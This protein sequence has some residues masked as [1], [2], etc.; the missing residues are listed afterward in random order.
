LMHAAKKQ[1]GR[2]NNRYKGKAHFHDAKVQVSE[3]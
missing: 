3:V 1:K 2:A